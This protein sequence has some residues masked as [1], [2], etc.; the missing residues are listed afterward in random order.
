MNFWSQ[1][2]VIARRDLR[3]EARAGEVTGV[4][5]PFAAIAVFVV[6]LATDTLT[7]RLADLGW[8]VY[9][10]VSLLF[11]MSVALRNSATESPTQRRHLLLLGVDP[12]ARFA[13]RAGAA[14]VLM[15]AVMSVTAP[16]MVLF[17]DPDG[18]PPIAL[19]AGVVVLFSTGL[20]MLATL[21]G[22]VTVGLRARSMLAPLL[23]APLAVPLVVG[24]ARAV[25]SVGRG[26]STLGPLMLL[27]IADLGLAISAIVTAQP[28]EEATT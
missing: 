28:L 10:L 27:V 4:I 5:L 7:V 21:A 12:V 14:A 24:S 8:P 16:L 19:W 23:V 26:T 9:W 13:G 18:L 11:G 3:I 1:A 25:E 22:D 15:I 6:P 20:A 17:Y 2:L